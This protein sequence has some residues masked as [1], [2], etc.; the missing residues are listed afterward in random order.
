MR[1]AARERVPIGQHRGGTPRK[2][3]NGRIPAPLG[4][5]EMRAGKAAHLK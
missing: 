2:L 3:P 5:K 4:G 1:Q